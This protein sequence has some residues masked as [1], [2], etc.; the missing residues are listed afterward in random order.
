V[1]GLSDQP[2]ESVLLSAR[3]AAV[4]FVAV[5]TGLMLQLEERRAVAR[6]V[7]LVVCGAAVYAL[8]ELA[9]PVSF[10]R[11]VV[12][13]G[14]YWATVK[15]QPFLLDPTGTGL[16][17][18]FFTATGERR[19]SGSFGDPLAAGYVLA[20]AIVLAGFTRELRWRWVL[21]SV[22]A[23]ALLLTFTRAGWLL[24]AGAVVPTLVIHLRGSQ[25][26]T[27]RGL[28]V[29]CIAILAG[30]AA[31]PKFR[32]YVVNLAEGRDASTLGH[33]EALRAVGDYH[34]S[35]FGQGLASSGASVGAGTESV[36]VTLALQLGLLGLL[37]Y[38][39]A[40]VLIAVRAGQRWRGECLVASYIGLLVAILI[41]V[42][43]SEQ[44]L[45]FNA[46]WPLMLLVG[47]AP[48]RCRRVRAE[49]TLGLRPGGADRG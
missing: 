45:T 12:G 26:N 34:Y 47:L 31:V 49:E 15:D 1:H 46:G 16:P 24:V 14:D 44:L 2:L 4:L 21:V 28:L 17:G 48:V 18:N 7:S 39:I 23:T 5:V 38:L 33:L 36:L 41:T 25:G 9:L 13:V 30:L 19:L 3:N 32:D 43:V 11:D 6:A 42:T 29:G 8:V 20:S 27:K 35:L 40:V 37:L 10:V 22:M